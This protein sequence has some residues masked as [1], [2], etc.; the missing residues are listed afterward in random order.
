MIRTILEGATI[1]DGTGYPRYSTDLALVDGRIGRIGDCTHIEAIKRMD[2]RGLLVA[3][4]FIDSSSQNE[5]A[6]LVAT[7]AQSK[8][9]QGI[10]TAIDPALMPAEQL[11]RIAHDVD[12]ALALSR[13]TRVHLTQFRHEHMERTLDEIDRARTRG[14]AITCDTWPYTYDLI[15]LATL[16]PQNVAPKQLRD[17][18]FAAL[19]A[20]EIATRV[21]DDLDARS[22][23]AQLA[24]DPDARGFIRCANEDD[25]AMLLSADFCAIGTGSPALRLRD[26]DERPVHPRAFGAMA[27]VFGRFVRQRRV[28]TVEEAVRRM[29]SLPARIFGLE[30]RGI[31]AEEA[32]ADLVLFEEAVFADTAT[33]ERPGSL[34]V[35]LAR[36]FAAGEEIYTK[37]NW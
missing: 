10:T 2:C 12:D 16:L 20:I 18:A 31:I 36:V 32:A 33:Y 15:E 21:G 35:G 7:S 28:L 9:A 5:D 14:A 3:P 34:P 37:E 17:P 1:V 6:W 25:V 29:T 8:V 23:V 13:E 4:A 24:R 19:A 27:R 26:L 30:H 11:P 22:V